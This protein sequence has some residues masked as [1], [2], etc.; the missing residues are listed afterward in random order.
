M[1]RFFIGALSFLFLTTAGVSQSSTGTIIKTKSSAL[2]PAKPESVGFSPERLKRI[3]DNINEW[4]KDGRLNGCAALIVRNGKIIYNKAFGYD[5]LEKTKPIRTDNIFRI[6]SQT[7]AITSTAIMILYEEG[8]F[9]LDDPISRYIPEFAKPQVLDKFNAADTTYTTVP[10]KSEI[11]IRQLLTH[12]SGI[13]Y[14]QIGTKE[15]NAIFA[16]TTI[17][18]GIGVPVGKILADDMKKLGKIPLMHQPGEKFTYGLNTDV[19][20]YLV[21]IISGMPLDEFFRKRI[22]DPLGMN[23]TYF[24]LPP[25][26][27]NRLV[28]LYEETEKK[29]VKAKP[30]TEQNGV[31][32]I[33]YPKTEG[34]YF[35]G[36]AGLSSTMLD[37]AIFLQMILNGGEYNGKR[38]LSRNT[39]R[40]MT[41]NQIGDVDRGANKFG[42]GFGITTEKGSSILPTP[43]GVFEWGGAFATTYWADPKEKL[44]GIFY[45]QLWKTT[46]GET[47]N[48]FKVLVYQALE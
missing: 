2:L 13:S 7:K 40:M 45:R 31:F 37:Y 19:L 5:D 4:L 44:I 20:G 35:S 32:L 10:S 34:T 6:A 9:L 22:F 48:K 8:K 46:I 14:A 15:A 28:T 47:A 17:T 3:D 29:L 30:V 12:T 39:V 1:K 21:E 41:M 26:K 43:E 27:Q 23:D 33:D 42:L 16:K 36:G 38:L 24:Y 25:A 11:T 18:A